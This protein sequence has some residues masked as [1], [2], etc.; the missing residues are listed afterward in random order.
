V[1]VPLVGM[2]LA[3]CQSVAVLSDPEAYAD[4]GDVVGSALERAGGILGGPD[5]SLANQ[6]ALG[7]RLAAQAL[8]R[9][10]LAEDE[11]LQ[12]HLSRIAQRIATH[13]GA[14]GLKF[15]VYLY[16]DDTPNAFTP[17]GGHIFVATGLVARLKTESQMAMVLA[18]EIAHNVD[19]HVVK[20][21][22]RRAV[23]RKATEA[24]KTVFDERL[25][26]SWVGEKLG[27]AI[28]ATVNLYTRDQEDAADEDGLDYLI[29]AGY[30]PREAEATFQ[31]LMA[32][33]KQSPLELDAES[34]KDRRT[35]RIRN[36]LRAKY[37]ERDFS[38]AILSTPEYDRLAG[39]YHMLA[40]SPLGSQ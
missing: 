11:A 33:S 39:R 23:S 6:K 22:H 36:L 5:T 15:R 13:A 8:E 16:E 31:A 1:L 4:A 2:S 38:P 24:S 28:N 14:K 30:D 32:A 20:G 7:D 35:A 9:V 40:P 17:G 21:A 12:S 25:G 18:H 3:G 26:L 27:L 29:A 10:Q 34:A 19:A 37:A